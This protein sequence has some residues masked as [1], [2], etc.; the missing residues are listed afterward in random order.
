MLIIVL[1]MNTVSPTTGILSGVPFVFSN[2][3]TPNGSFY[4]EL[5]GG[6]FSS[7]SLNSRQ[8]MFEIDANSNWTVTFDFPVS[9]LRL[10]CKFWRTTEVEFDQP[11][12]IL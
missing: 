9:N 6:D 3:T 11:F 7:A 4:T 12:T 5:S 10:Y 1:L 8:T 2:V